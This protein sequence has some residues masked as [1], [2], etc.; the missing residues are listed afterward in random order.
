MGKCDLLTGYGF[1]YDSDL[2]SIDDS[3]LS[4]FYIILDL[5]ILDNFI[6]RISFIRL[7]AS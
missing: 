5:I 2:I 4:K 3:S 6:S 7:T 1:L